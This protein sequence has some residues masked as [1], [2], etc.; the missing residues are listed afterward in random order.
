M[1]HKNILLIGVLPPP[2][3]GQ[4]LDFQSLTNGLDT[5]VLTLSGMKAKNFKIKTTK[6]LIYLRLLLRLVGIISFKKYVVYHTLSQSKEG[7]MRDFPIVFISKLFGCKV[8]GHIHGGNYDGFY[9]K[10]NTFF[11]SLIRKMLIQMDSMIVLSENMKKM[12]DFVPEI[13]F[14][15]KVVNNGL[16]WYFEGNLLKTKSLP[17][18]IQEPIKI[19]FLSNLI[20]SKGYLEV[21]ET[22]E[23]LANRYGYNV[24]TDFCGEFVHYADAQRFNNLVDAK[25]HFFDFITKNKLQN[26]VNYHGVVTGDKKK[27]LLEEAH[28][29][30]L[31]TNYINEGQPI[32]IIE[33]M[34]YRCVV[35]T[36]HYRGISEMISSNESGVYVDFGSPESFASE[37]KKLIENPAEF[38]KISA[39][40][41]QVFQEKFTKEKHLRALIN[42]IKRHQ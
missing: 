42:E 8:I 30:I 20:E 2:I 28:F 15:I 35:L 27:Q 37:V 12:F 32:S 17:Q 34:A 29:F 16:P 23:I 7:F 25:R 13:C 14:K 26:H 1:K 39:N 5:K 11:Q 31:P 18:K 38:A 6:I 24:Q 22:T 3:N 4:T 40:G 9:R 41:H 10:Q 21:L 33:A 19:L 36:T